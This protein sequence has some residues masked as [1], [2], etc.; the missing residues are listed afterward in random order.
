MSKSRCILSIAVVSFY[1]FG[2]ATAAGALELGVAWAGKS[3]MAKRVTAGFEKGM[4]EFAPDVNIEYKKELGS[5][6]KLAEV[7]AR[8]QKEKAGMV[9]LRSNGA[10]WLAKN[11]PNIPTFIGGCN[12]PVQLGAVKNMDAP[13][14]NITGVTYYLPARVQF[15]TFQAILPAMKS[16]LL[17]AGAG[18]PSAKIDEAETREVCAEL[19]LEYNE[20]EVSSGEE[21]VAAVKDL[22][23]KV[24]AVIIGNQA[25]VMD[26]ASDIVAAAGKTP[27]FSYSS[28][29]VKDG[30]LGGF[31]ADDGA[32]GYMLAQTV[33]DVLI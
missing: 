3:G 16:V 4:K 15:E 25:V 10:K 11:P 27:V 8:F 13:E 28:K 9:I 19:G 7:A 31:V 26:N 21:A 1:F 22:G 18:N 6:D 33:V 20:K 24:S 23:G 5:V 32:L 30:A 17:L 12:N 29:P 14:G 2:M